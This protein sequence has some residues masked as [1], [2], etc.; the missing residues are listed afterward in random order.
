MVLFRL[1]ES[2]E[3]ERPVSSFLWIS[4]FWLTFLSIQGGIQGKKCFKVSLIMNHS[5]FKLT[6]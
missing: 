3:S 6:F 2:L 5:F 1:A 4:R